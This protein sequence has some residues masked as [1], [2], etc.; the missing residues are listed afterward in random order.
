M[1]VVWKPRF[2]NGTEDYVI[3]TTV[4][5]AV[6]RTEQGLAYL[7]GYHAVETLLSCSWNPR[8]DDISQ[9]ILC[10]QNS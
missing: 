1:H 7:R 5:L 8:A 3:V 4:R 10:H 6:V 9:Y 2:K